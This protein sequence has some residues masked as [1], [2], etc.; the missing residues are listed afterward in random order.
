MRL[1]KY[2]I[3]LVILFALSCDENK[4]SQAFLSQSDVPQVNTGDNHIPYV[5]FVAETNCEVEYLLEHEFLND[6][7]N[8]VLS[9]NLIITSL[10]HNCPFY[11]FSEKEVEIHY[12]FV[13]DFNVIINGIEITGL[14]DE[15]VSEESAILPFELNLEKI[16]KDCKII[17]TGSGQFEEIENDPIITF[18]HADLKIQFFHDQNVGLCKLPF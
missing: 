3:L 1:S 17:V 10:Q 8:T 6:I 7:G 15:I 18:V 5:P 12:Q 4:A 2:L 13:P 9:S 14:V 11:L 16:V